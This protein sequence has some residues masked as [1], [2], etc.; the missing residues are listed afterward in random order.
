[1]KDLIKQLLRQR[2]LDRASVERLK[3][4][5]AEK[6][7]A[8]IPL[9]S[10]ILAAATPREIAKLKKFLITKPTRTLSG[11]A[12]VALMTKPAGCPGKC[13]YCPT[14]ADV[15]KSYTGFE[16][17]TMRARRNEFDS[18]K[19]VKN[20]LKQ[21]KSVGH[22]TDKCEVIIQGGTFTWLSWSYQKNFVKRAYD[23]FNGKDSK[24]LEQAKK[25]NE[26]AQ[27]RV[28]SLI[29]ETRPDFCSE[30]HIKQLLELG[31]TRVELGLQSVYDTILKKVKRGHDLQTCKD[32]IRNLK[33]TGFKVDL[34]IMIGLPGSTK[35][36]DIKMFK[37]LFS[38]ED[39]RPDGLKIYPCAVIQGS[40][41]YKDWK[42]GKYKPISDKYIIDVLSEVKAKYIPTY[43][44]IKRIMRDIPSN[45]IEA[46]Y[47]YPNLREFI[48][49][50]MAEKGLECRCIRCREIGHRFWKHG[51]KPGKI[52]LIVT[53]YGASEGEE[54]FI[55]AEDV[56]N[57]I[58]IGFARLRIA[59]GKAF[60]RELH[61]YGQEIPLDNP[62]KNIFITAQHKG[63]GKKLL[64]TAEQIAKHHKMK[65]ILVLAGAGVKEY[66]RKLGYRDQGYYVA[67]NLF[68]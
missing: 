56:K 38:D 46:G 51:A 14:S 32:A 20:R 13:T 26:K 28:V 48:H 29:I 30:K 31:A 53:R 33:N 65:E 34:H 66:Y 62:G 27:H 57:D 39:L 42:A 54:F 40:Q 23:A 6:H 63:F 16:P 49:K 60:L 22:S 4:E 47:T 10:Q 67:K 35:A 2:N 8:K 17:S 3:L 5:W 61:V 55:S 9:N 7:N 59:E 18:Y 58:L 37:I 21:L 64:E 25:L 50:K 45:Y 15:P 44:R 12:T 68:Q 11:V 43:V 36:S 52:Q 19:I 1:M 24:N 41:L